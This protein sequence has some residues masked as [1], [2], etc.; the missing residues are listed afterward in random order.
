MTRDVPPSAFPEICE[1]VAP[2]LRESKQLE[3]QTVPGEALISLHDIHLGFE[4]REVL[5]EFHSM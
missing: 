5:P 1:H 3:I 2:A 4:D